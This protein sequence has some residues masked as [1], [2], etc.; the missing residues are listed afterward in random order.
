V[1]CP[2]EE[3]LN[4]EGANRRY[5]LSHKKEITGTGKYKV[6][7]LSPSIVKKSA[8]KRHDAVTN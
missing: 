2:P 6:D 5:V 8:E 4:S 1:G 7:S 3:K